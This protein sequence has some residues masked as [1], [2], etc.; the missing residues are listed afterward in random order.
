LG[1]TNWITIGE[2]RD[3]ELFI[4]LILNEILRLKNHLDKVFLETDSYSNRRRVSNISSTGLHMFKNI[5]STEFSKE[6]ILT[7]IVKLSLKTFI[8]CVRLTIFGTSG[9]QQLQV[10]VYYMRL[11]LKDIIP[12][13]Y[14]HINTLLEDIVTS[15]QD[16]TINPKD[17]EPFIKDKICR[18]TL[19]NKDQENLDDL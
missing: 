15:A 2:P 8:E 14:T 5:L 4:K 17:V 12:D 16:R 11:F 10:D 13:P 19:D 1:A 18:E 3:V 9:Y 6:A 7:S